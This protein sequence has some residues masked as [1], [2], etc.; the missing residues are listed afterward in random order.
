MSSL[1]DVRFLDS[2]SISPSGF[3]V[4]KEFIGVRRYLTLSD[5][6]DTDSNKE[7]ENNINSE[8][9]EKNYKD[10]FRTDGFISTHTA[11]KIRQKILWL[12]FLA[13]IKSNI[14]QIQSDGLNLNC[15][16]LL[17]HFQAN[18]DIQIR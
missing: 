8:R 15:A 18:N 9:T 6:F 11:K 10:R 12:L 4:Y 3:A 1:N 16:S 2:I 14:Y 13:R 17:L 5:D 7:K